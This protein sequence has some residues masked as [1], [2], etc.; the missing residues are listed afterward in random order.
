[1]I[2]Q[3]AM[4]DIDSLAE[5]GIKLTPQ[6]II[7]LNAFGLKVERGT[8][9]AERFALP[10]VAVLGKLTLR[11]PTIGSEI[12]MS[13]ASQVCETSSAETFLVLRLYSLSK[14]QSQLVDPYDRDKLLEELTA[15]K[16]VILPF[17]Y[18]QV[19][20]ALDYVVAGLNHF[21]GEKKSTRRRKDEEDDDN[22]EDFDDEYSCIEIG[23]LK[24]G[25]VLKLGTLQELKTMTTSGLQ[26]LLQ[27]ATEVKYYESAYKSNKNK[28]L[29]EYYSVLEDIKDN[30]K[31]DLREDGEDKD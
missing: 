27:Y 7:R 31:K 10:R 19:T 24:D 29:I 15:M 3:M 6:E 1:M 25:M 13:Q 28:R 2:S 14:D 9:T 8:D 11:Q 17:T 23:M 16:E 18:E 4:E 22:I 26:M 30:H 21:D 12:W 20:G 5:E